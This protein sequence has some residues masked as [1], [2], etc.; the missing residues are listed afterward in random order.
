ML[1]RGATKNGA[2]KNVVI[3]FTGHRF[4]F[5]FCILFPSPSSCGE[6]FSVVFPRD[7]GNSD[8]KN[9]RPDSRVGRKYG[10]L[11]SYRESTEALLLFSIGSAGKNCWRMCIVNEVYIF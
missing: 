3:F 11:S 5:M 9:K 2:T 10:I 4:K 8:I 6:D 7:D 1:F